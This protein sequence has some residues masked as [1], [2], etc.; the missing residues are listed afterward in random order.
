MSDMRTSISYR[1]IQ[2]SHTPRDTRLRSLNLQTMIVVIANTLAG[3]TNKRRHCS[4]ST[5]RSDPSNYSWL[6]RSCTG[7]KFRNIDCACI[8]RAVPCI[9]SSSSHCPME[10]QHH[11]DNR[12]M[13]SATWSRMFALCQCWPTRRWPLRR[14]QILSTLYCYCLL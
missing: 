11:R 14:P 1:N 8:A 13:D 9:Y 6:W 7:S 4:H 10:C 5:P 2:L 12:Y 3:Y